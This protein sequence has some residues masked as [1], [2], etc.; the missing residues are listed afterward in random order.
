MPFDW[1]KDPGMFQQTMVVILENVKW[2]PILFYLEYIVL[3]SKTPKRG[4][5]HIKKVLGLQQAIVD[6]LKMKRCFF[7]MAQIDTLNM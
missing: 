7:S 3:N 4:Y 6:T 2:Q 1:K 5:Y